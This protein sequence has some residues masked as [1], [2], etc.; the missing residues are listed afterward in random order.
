MT[1]LRIASNSLVWAL[2]ELALTAR[3]AQPVFGDYGS[4]QIR[5]YDANYYFQRQMNELNSQ[6]GNKA[7]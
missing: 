6:L 3:P 2:S 4:E 1:A 5:L 7:K